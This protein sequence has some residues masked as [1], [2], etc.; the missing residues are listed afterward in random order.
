MGSQAGLEPSR[1]SPAALS[2]DLSAVRWAGL[3]DRIGID[4]FFERWLSPIRK[5]KKGSAAA[6]CM[7]RI[8]LFLFY[9]TSRHLTR[10]DT[11]KDDAGSAATIER[12]P[13]DLLSL[14]AVKRF[15]SNITCD[16]IWLLRKVLQPDPYLAAR[17]EKPEVVILDLDVMALD[18]DDALNREGVAPTDT[19]VYT[20]EKY[21]P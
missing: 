14:H 8:L 16:R 4:W 13:D 9:G 3:T 17:L 6:E 20:G 5:N 12:T 2:A 19:L 7:R 1:C 11:L 15:F 10:F 18:N 21:V